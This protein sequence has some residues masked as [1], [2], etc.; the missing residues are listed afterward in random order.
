MK[1]FLMALLN[2][3]NEIETLKDLI[4]KKNKDMPYH[5]FSLETSYN[6]NFTIG[7]YVDGGPCIAHCH[8]DNTEMGKKFVNKNAIYH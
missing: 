1:A 8:L 2:R 7:L 6:G 5:Y 3:R 4:E